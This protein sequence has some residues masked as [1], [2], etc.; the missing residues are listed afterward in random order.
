[1]STR[2]QVVVDDAEL[3]RFRRAAKAAGMTL[4]EWA[5][6]ALRGAERRQS[7]ADPAAKLAAVRSAT[8]HGFPAPDIDQMLE[9]VEHGYRD[10]AP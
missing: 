10:A 7:S 1:M 5:R 8:R 6:Q 2:L 4:S 9:E 3:R